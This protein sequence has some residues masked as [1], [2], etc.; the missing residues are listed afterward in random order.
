MSKIQT[1][2]SGLGNCKKHYDLVFWSN[3]RYTNKNRSRNTG[4]ILQVLLKLPFLSD[5]WKFG[6]T[7]L[8][9]PKSFFKKTFPDCLL[10]TKWTA[11]RIS[12]GWCF[13]TEIMPTE[14]CLWK[15]IYLSVRPIGKCENSHK[16]VFSNI[17]DHF[18]LLTH[19]RY[20]PKSLFHGSNK[21]LRFLF[22]LFFFLKCPAINL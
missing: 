13:G 16:L 9:K 10:H 11:L 4:W 7:K 22:L 8:W 15:D 1:H 5:P 14:M 18:H 6:P 12:L 19:P 3:S 21:D 20:W 17:Y 2:Q